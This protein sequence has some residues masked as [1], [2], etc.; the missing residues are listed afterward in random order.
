[1]KDQGK[2]G[3]SWAFS[4]TGALEGRLYGATRMLTRLSE[5]QLLDCTLDYG[6]K[7]CS[8]GTAIASFSYI[9]NFGGICRASDYPYLGYVGCQCNC[10]TIHTGSVLHAGV[11]LW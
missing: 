11:L 1:M 3:S 5:Q 2:C 8:G 4:A 9:Q 7:G 6:N 10:V